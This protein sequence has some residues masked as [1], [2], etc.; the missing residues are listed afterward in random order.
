MLEYLRASHAE[1]LRVIADT[2]KLE[3]ETEK[4]LVEALDAFAGIFQVSGGVEAS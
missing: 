1:V 3:D 2:G 4:Q